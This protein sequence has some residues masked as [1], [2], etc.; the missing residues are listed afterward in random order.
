MTVLVDKIL[1]GW[2]RW[3]AF[4]SL[5]RTARDLTAAQVFETLLRETGVD[6]YF[7]DLGRK[8]D[9]DND[10]LQFQVQRVIARHEHKTT[11]GR[12]QNGSLHRLRSGRPIAQVPFGFATDSEGFPEEG[13]SSE[14]DV[15]AI[16]VDEACRTDERGSVRRIC[17]TLAA[18]ESL[19]QAVK[20]EGGNWP[21]AE[22][23]VHKILG[24]NLELYVTG[25]L[26]GSFLDE[27]HELRPVTLSRR[28]DPGVA[29]LARRTTQARKGTAKL[30]KVHEN[31]LARVPIFHA[32]C[33]G[34][35]HP[36][37]KPV[38]LQ[39]RQHKGELKL[40][41]TTPV[42]RDSTCRGVQLDARE[43]QRVIA[44]EFVKMCEHLPHVHLISDE[45]RRQLR[46]DI[47]ALEKRVV[48]I[49][50]EWV[51]ERFP[52]TEE[53]LRDACLDIKIG[54]RN[55][56]ET[57]QRREALIDLLPHLPQG[58]DPFGRDHLLDALHELAGNQSDPVSLGRLATIYEETLDSIVLL[59]DED[60][61][62]VELRGPRIH[63]G[64]VGVQALWPL[65][66][67]AP[68]LVE[69]LYE[70]IDRNRGVAP[71]SGK[72]RTPRQGCPK[73]R[74]RTYRTQWVLLSHRSREQRPSDVGAGTNAFT[75]S[76]GSSSQPAQ[77][78]VLGK[79]VAL[80][81]HAIK[82]AASAAAKTRASEV[83]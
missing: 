5:D 58:V 53:D 15:I 49:A 78:D 68:I 50:A 43:I 33:L 45:A 62:R 9:W 70:R 77:L 47:S 74:V 64:E 60:G 17:E 19:A 29:R 31:P 79:P 3:V 24:P 26:V 8:V 56:L 30:T 37:G 2:V 65:Q 18:D 46:R 61:Y 67:A 42:P 82:T 81:A 54:A 80:T 21:I 7:A 55:E 83:P 11:S 12:T 73:R 13:P 76:S 34:T 32:P 57:L 27:E 28:L 51:W 44:S 48:E 25:Q 36:N 59:I 39:W 22:S 69:H 1:E 38:R 35:L 63:A 40:L 6:L 75:Y 20:A 41:H 23:T 16:V 4:R 72:V 66:I 71:N 10:D 14:W 52:E